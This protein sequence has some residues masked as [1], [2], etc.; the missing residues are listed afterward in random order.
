MFSEGLGE[1]TAAETLADALAAARAPGSRR[2]DPAESRVG[3]TTR[4]FADAV[5]SLLPRAHRNAE[6]HPGIL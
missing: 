1:H 6:F 3:A 4:E 5:L 2:D